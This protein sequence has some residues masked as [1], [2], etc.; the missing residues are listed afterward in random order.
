MQFFYTYLL[1]VPI[2]IAIDLLWTGVVARGLYQRRLGPLLKRVNWI[3]AFLFYFIFTVGLTFFAILPALTVDTVWYAAALGAMYGLFTY[4]TYD[5]TNQ[6][7]LKGWPLAITVI[8]II[9][10]TFLGGAVASLTYVIA[11][12]IF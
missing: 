1:S 12:L 6:A 3:A 8:D 10:G 11:G 9:W 4:A 7:T 2:F 5:L